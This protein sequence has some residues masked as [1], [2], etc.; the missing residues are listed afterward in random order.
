MK[1][2]QPKI[3]TIKCFGIVIMKFS[4]KQILTIKWLA[5]TILAACMVYSP[6]YYIDEPMQSNYAWVWG[7]LI[8]YAIW[9]KKKRYV[10]K[11]IASFGPGLF[12]ISFAISFIIFPSDWLVTL[13]I[14]NLSTL[15]LSAIWIKNPLKD[16]SIVSE[17]IYYRER[18]SKD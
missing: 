13:L 14:V 6:T 2:S 10:V 17:D 1:F 18:E 8:L 7:I 4:K 11:S 12:A 16:K 3:L 9:T 5:T 15:I